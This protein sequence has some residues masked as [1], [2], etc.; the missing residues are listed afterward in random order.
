MSEFEYTVNRS[1]L[2]VK[3]LTFS[4]GK[5]KP[6]VL[7]NLSFSI[8][9]I[10]RPNKGGPEGELIVILGESGSGKSTLLGLLSGILTPQSGEIQIIDGLGSTKMTSVKQGMVGVVDQASTLFEHLTVQKNLAFAASLGGIPKE[11]QKAA[12]SEILRD[13]GL[14]SHG[15]KYPG[16]LSGGQ[17]QRVA[18]ARQILRQPSVIIFDEPFS[19]LDYKSKMQAMRLIQQVSNIHTDQV[20]M[21]ITHDI[22]VAVQIADRILFLEQRADGSGAHIA[23]EFNLMDLGIAWR[24]NNQLLP[25]YAQVVNEIQQRS[26]KRV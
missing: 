25:E 3:D 8:E 15:G 6:N 16:Q 9:D 23:Q 14:E 12:V 18:I 5:G 11:Q 22:Y 26:L 4:Y 17:R 2:T 10:Q 1:I 24:P 19:G 13:F 7:S 20:V 21:V